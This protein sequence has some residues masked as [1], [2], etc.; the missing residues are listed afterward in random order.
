M[1]HRGN[2]KLIAGSANPKLAK[3]IAASMGHPLC[4]SEVMQFSEGNT[5]VRVLENVRGCDCFIIQGVNYPVDKNF[6]ELLF[7]V[8]ALR[9][10]SAAHITA[11]LPFFSYSKA[12]KKDEPRVSLRARVCADALEAC[13]VDRILTMDLHSPQIQGFFKKPVDHMHARTIIT[14]HIKEKGL[15]NLVVASADVGYG[16]DAFKFAEK[17]GCQA[18]IGN[19]IRADHSEKA[20]VWSVVGDVKGKD[21]LIV[22]DIV[23]TGGSLISMAEAVRKLGAK[24]VYAAVTHGVLTKGAAEKIEKSCLKELLIT[25]SVEYRF[26][27]ECSKV[28]VLS[29]ARLFGEVIENI[30]KSASISKL[31]V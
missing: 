31:F 5:F 13:G 26:E 24:D 23:F 17:L 9:L 30:H 20:K 15:K 14:S 22:D 18:V 6:M 16:K 19:K 1:S 21:V 2:L 27:K 7:W 12:D 28:K 25:D 3:A 29:V 4:Q 10:A 8:D 11:V